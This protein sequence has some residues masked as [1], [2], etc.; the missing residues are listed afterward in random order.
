MEADRPWSD[1]RRYHDCPASS[2]RPRGGRYAAF[3]RIEI[4]AIGRAIEGEVAAVDDE[5]G[6]SAVDIFAQAMK[7]V[8]QPGQ[9]AGE[10]GVGNL[11][12]AKLG[13]AMILFAGSYLSFGVGMVTN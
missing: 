9:A 13:H 11:G 12:Q 10:M 5:I 4:V 7:I 3:W 6:A 2:G 8:G 1:C